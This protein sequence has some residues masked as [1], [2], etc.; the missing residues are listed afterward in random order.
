MANLDKVRVRA[1]RGT[2]VLVKTAGEA[3]PLDELSIEDTENEDFLQRLIDEHANCLPLEEIDYVYGNAVAICR[4]LETGHGPIDN[5]LM[6][7]DGGLVLIEAKLCRNHDSVRKVVAQALDYASGIFEMDYSGFEA[8]VLKAQFGSKEKPRERPKRLYDLFSSHREAKT[9]RSFIDAVGDNLRRGRA[10]ILVIGDGIR[11]EAE[12]LAKFV[13]SNI[14]Q[15]F[16]FALIQLDVFRMPG[17]EQ[18]VWPR[19]LAK[20]QLLNRI[21][22]R[23][24]DMRAHVAVDGPE[25]KGAGRLPE[26]V[27]A[28]EFYEAIAGVRPDLPDRVRHFVAKL[29][30]SAVQP[31]YRKTLILRWENPEGKSLN[32][33]YI[34]RNGQIW[35]DGLSGSVPASLRD[36]YLRELAAALGAGVETDPAG[37]AKNV[38]KDTHAPRLSDIGDKLDLWIPVI[39][40]FLDRLKQNIAQKDI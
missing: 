9:E 17:G 20:T 16:T 18:L 38:R 13:E 2:P 4:E 39:E 12:R 14:A 34:D 5:L 7:P 32:L 28:E 37:F 6:T 31:D 27:S 25:G 23:I 21:T 1:Q 19:T 15:H 8:A 24:D 22:V 11:P 10:L 30:S 29:A 36:Q 3:V 40:R 35:T 33:G 26:N